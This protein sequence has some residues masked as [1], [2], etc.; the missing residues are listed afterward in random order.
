MA[1]DHEI[2]SSILNILSALRPSYA[3]A[4][5]SQLAIVESFGTV[6]NDV[7]LAFL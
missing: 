1:F 2:R 4:E 3:I 5:P 6:I 7:I